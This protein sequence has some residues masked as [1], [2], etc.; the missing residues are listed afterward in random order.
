[1]QVWE[2]VPKAGKGWFAWN[3][4]HKRSFMATH[5][6]K[7]VTQKNLRGLVSFPAQILMQ[8]Q[9]SQTEVGLWE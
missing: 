1:M 7:T 3:G 2:L 9:L 8:E 6:W 4:V 5:R